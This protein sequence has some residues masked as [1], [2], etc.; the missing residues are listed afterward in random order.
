MSGPDKKGAFKCSIHGKLLGF[1]NVLTKRYVGV[2]F[3]GYPL[4]GLGKP[5]GKPRNHFGGVTLLTRKVGSIVIN[6]ILLIRV[7]S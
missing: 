6:P 5:K 7:F 1:P 4:V 2:L 3:V